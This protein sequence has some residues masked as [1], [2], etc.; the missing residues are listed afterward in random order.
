MLIN[1]SKCTLL[2]VDVQEKL[3]KKIHNYKFIESSILKISH[4]FNLLDIPIVYS[5]QYPKGLGSTIKTLKQQLKKKNSR[6]FEKTSFSC[7][8]SHNNVNTKDWIKTEQIIICGIETHICV[9]QTALDLIIQGYEVF[10]LNE[11]VGSRSK[12]DNFLAFQRLRKNNVSIVS[13]EMLV[14]ELVRNSEHKHF[15]ELSKLIK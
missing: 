8:P 3:F 5:E 4:I 11:G 15:K 1:S 6:K 13:I 7:F 10:V 2:I 14:F 12:D 9:L